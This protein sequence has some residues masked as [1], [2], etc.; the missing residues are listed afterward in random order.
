LRDSIDGL[1]L[2]ERGTMPLE[3][4]APTVD[5]EPREPANGGPIP[6]LYGMGLGLDIL[7]PGPARGEA[8]F[9]GGVHGFQS[10]PLAIAPRIIARIIA[11]MSGEKNH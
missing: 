7:P 10:Y 4:G 1:P 9:G 8:S 2:L 3:V 11:R 5:G 6:G